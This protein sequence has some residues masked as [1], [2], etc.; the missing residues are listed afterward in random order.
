MAMHPDFH[1]ARSFDVALD[2]LAEATHALGFDA[3][4]Y[5]FMAKARTHDGRYNAPDIAWRNWP[6]RIAAGWSRYCR[7]DPF[8]CAGYPRTLPLDWQQVKGASWLSPIQ[9]EALSYVEGIGIGDGLTVPIHLPEGAFAFVT[10][11]THGGHDTW[12]ARQA[13]VTDELFVMAH[14]FHAAI[15]PRFGFKQR[16][17]PQGIRLSPREREVLSLAAAGLSAPE[18][19]RRAHRSVET[20]RRQRKSAMEKLGAHSIAQAVALAMSLALLDY[21]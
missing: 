8:L 10:A 13:Q 19:A 12:R 6:T 11:V 7:V 18:S 15:A 14:E 17:A 20:V 5:G 4:D 16:A 3:V 21:A 2:R 9:Q 1:S